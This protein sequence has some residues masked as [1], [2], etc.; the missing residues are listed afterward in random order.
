MKAGR[1]KSPLSETKNAILYESEKLFSEKGFD[2][3]SID[4]ISK[5]VGITKAAIYYHFT[6]KHGIME[7]IITNFIR[8]SLAVQKQQN[9]VIEKVMQDRLSVPNVVPELIE[10]M[11]IFLNSRIKTLKIILM[12]SIKDSSGNAPIFFVMEKY[13]SACGQMCLDCCYDP[14]NTNESK[15]KVE[16]FFL[17]Y[18]PLISFVIFHEKWSEYQNIKKDEVINIFGKAYFDTFKFVLS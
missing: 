2:A 11:F 13:F 10:E 9:E 16:E 4:H 1:K 15:T 17:K 8:E 18:I 6:N 12:E 14:K 3:T 5:K 7:S